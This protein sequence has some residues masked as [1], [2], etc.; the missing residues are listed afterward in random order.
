MALLQRG[1]QTGIVWFFPFSPH[2]LKFFR[3]DLLGLPV[4][5]NHFS[6]FFAVLAIMGVVIY[7]WPTWPRPEKK[8]RILFPS[9]ASFAGRAAPEL[10]QVSRARPLC[11]G[12]ST[13]FVLC[14][15]CAGNHG[16]Q[17]P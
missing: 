2:W 13:G 15:H 12:M 1:L 17:L 16:Y 7:G 10:G 6:P 8:K 9:E 4:F 3:Q 14:N 11:A 5:T